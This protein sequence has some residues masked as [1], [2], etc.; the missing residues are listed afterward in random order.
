MFYY[1]NW[2]AELVVFGFLFLSIN[3]FFW[4]TSII[5]LVLFVLHTISPIPEGGDIFA[6]WA[7][8]TLLMVLFTTKM[9]LKA[10]LAAPIGYFIGSGAFSDWVKRR[11]L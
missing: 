8:S 7:F 11:L 4:R 10:L 5:G 9:G 2:F 6:Y 1:D 3:V